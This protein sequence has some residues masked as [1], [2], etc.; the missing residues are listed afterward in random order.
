[1]R[2]AA[3]RC[4]TPTR[5]TAPPASPGTARSTTRSPR[6]RRSRGRSFR[7]G[8]TCSNPF[9]AETAEIAEKR[10][11]LRLVIVNETTNPFLHR[12]PGE[13]QKQPDGLLHQSQI[14]Q[15]LLG[16][17]LGQLLH[18]LDLDDQP[19]VHKEIHSERRR[20]CYPVVFDRNWMLTIDTIASPRKA[21]RQHH[22]IDRF[23]QAGAELPMDPYGFANHVRA[24][25]IDRDHRLCV[26][27]GL[28]ARNQISFASASMSAI[29][30]TL[31]TVTSS[32]VRPIIGP[33]TL[34]PSST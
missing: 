13:I 28:C 3:W 26:L 32:T 27:C 25:L 12:Q 5:P 22:L 2:R 31:V 8:R 18:G 29:V 20:E 24:D 19:F 6:W 21:C 15:H 23:E 1:G 33:R 34:P 10:L 14:R 9:R 4:S 11:I 7:S 16:V 17:N 30:T